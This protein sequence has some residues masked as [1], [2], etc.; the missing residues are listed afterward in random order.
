MLLSVA[1]IGFCCFLTVSSAQVRS[2]MSDVQGANLPAQP[3]GANDLIGVSVYDAPELTGTLRV[4]ADGFIRLPMLKQPIKAQG[5]M[6]GQLEAVVAEALRGEHILVDPF[7]KVTVAEYNSHPISVAGAVNQ[8][9]TFQATGPVTLLEA[10]TRA[11]GLAPE[12]GAEILVTNGKAS[13]VGATPPLVQRVLV[14]GLMDPAYPAL[15]VVLKGGEEIRV[16][17]KGKVYVMGNV[18]MPGA[19]SMEDTESTVLKVLALSQGLMPYAG[20]EAYIYRRDA[21]GDNHEIIIP[22]SKIL[23]RKAPDESLLA[24]DIL[25]VSDNKRRRMTFEALDRIL[26]LGSG[27]GAAAVYTLR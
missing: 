1:V 18:K 14:K 2:E 22:L 20:K 16:P 8:P 21:N 27:A 3:I 9:I 17:E 4:G 10:I 24:N 12:A 5:L 7:V 25:Y 15:N 26:L 13:P 11:G 19:Y 23:E 6:P